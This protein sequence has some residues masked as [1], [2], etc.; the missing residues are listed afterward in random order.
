MSPTD[1][2]NQPLSCAKCGKCEED[3]CTLKNCNA[4]KMVK[5][6]NRDC[7]TAHRPQHKKA[8]KKRA[9]ELHD[10]ELFKLPPPPEDCPIC[11]LPVPS[12]DT[13]EKYN[14]C[15]G[16]KICS[17]C[18]HAVMIE[19]VSKGKMKEEEIANCAGG[20]GLCPFCRTPTSDSE[21][22]I[23]RLKKRVEVDDAKAT[24]NLGCYYHPED[25]QTYSKLIPLD[26]D[27]ALELWHRAGELGCAEAYYN[28]AITYSLGNGVERDAKKENHYLE[29]S[30]MGGDPEARHNL[31]VEE[32]CKGAMKRALKHA[33]IATGSGHK[34]SLGLIQQ[35]YKDGY[36]SKDDYTKA[37]RAYQAYLSEIKSEQRDEAAAF[38][39]VMYNYY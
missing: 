13:G 26:M 16:K 9:A 14:S 29:L 35:M 30:A 7:Q 34:K 27:K 17:G 6:C 38:D 20:V 22:D 1:N 10:I 23:R 36:V 8:C 11:M 24:Y 2:N 19:A 32:A 15:C 5:Y 18:V 4:C 25:H 37:L 3:S 39:E 33:L 21:E 31:G 28:I 12:M